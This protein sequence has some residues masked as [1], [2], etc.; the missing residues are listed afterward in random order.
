MSSTFFA[1]PEMRLMLWEALLPPPRRIY[2]GG[3]TEYQ[4]KSNWGGILSNFKEDLFILWLCAESR[5]YCI[6]TAGYSIFGYDTTIP[7]YMN[8]SKDRLWFFN[9]DFPA[10]IQRYLRDP[11]DSPPDMYSATFPFERIRE[12][13]LHGASKV[14]KIGITSFTLRPGTSIQN[15]RCNFARIDCLACTFLGLEEI[16]LEIDQVMFEKR[17]ILEK[18]YTDYFNNSKLRLE[19]R[20]PLRLKFVVLRH[21]GS[22]NKTQTYDVNSMG[23][24]RISTM[25]SLR[26]P[27]SLLGC[28]TKPVLLN[29][30]KYTLWFDNMD[31]FGCYLVA[32]FGVLTSEEDLLGIARGYNEK[33]TPMPHEVQIPAIPLNIGTEIILSRNLMNTVQRIIEIEGGYFGLQCRMFTLREICPRRHGQNEEIE[34]RIRQLCR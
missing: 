32:S 6:R 27:S 24:P 9:F 8:H 2:M 13:K 10:D 31:V 14:K 4:L 3:D 34:R 26:R 12:P 23:L 1:I 15:H 33:T 5:D 16:T 20:K 11:P 30:Y 21:T 28:L 17:S 25:S 19:G 7:T 18:E 22:R 29:P